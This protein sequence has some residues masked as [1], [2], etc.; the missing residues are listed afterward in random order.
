MATPGWMRIVLVGAVMLGASCTAAPRQRPLPIGAVNKG[1]GTV[2]QARE[3]L[4]GRW[5]L[6]S[7]ELFPPN[8]AAIHVVGSGQLVYDDFANLTVDLRVDEATARLFERIGISAPNGVISTSGRTLV[9]MT[10]RTLSYTLEGQQAVR[11]ATHPLDTNRPRYWE[12]DGNTL[13]LRTKDD[14]GK[15]ISVAVWRKE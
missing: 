14:T 4:Q 9:D 1:P 6:V 12:V 8:E 10:S 2:T 5:S 13:T 15:V 11:P 3:Y 7:M